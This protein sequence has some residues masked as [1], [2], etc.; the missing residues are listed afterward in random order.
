MANVCRQVK[1]FEQNKCG[2]IHLQ[3]RW[4]WLRW[5][6]SCYKLSSRQN[7]NLFIHYP[8]HNINPFFRNRCCLL[9]AMA[10]CFFF[11]PCSM[12][13]IVNHVIGTTTKKFIVRE[14]TLW[15]IIPNDRPKR[16]KKTSGTKQTNYT[17]R[18]I[19]FVQW[20][21]E[22]PF[23]VAGINFCSPWQTIFRLLKNEH[24][25]VHITKFKHYT[26]CHEH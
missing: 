7:L 25:N 15:Q 13:R 24:T 1:W 22:K 8:V 21:K 14:I 9:L 23:L 6:S 10:I 5:I 16:K 12:H 2:C 3:S 26:N 19:C 18:F 11:L 20:T 4:F 17:E